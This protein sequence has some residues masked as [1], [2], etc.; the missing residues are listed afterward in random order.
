M[1]V[2]GRYTR[3]SLKALGVVL[4]VSSESKRSPIIGAHEG[5]AIGQCYRSTSGHAVLYDAANYVP[6]ATLA[7]IQFHA[8]G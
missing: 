2:Y 1:Y 3:R 4:M 7:F 8:S 5:S 6:T